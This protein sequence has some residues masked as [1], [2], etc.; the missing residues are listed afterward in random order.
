MR[1]NVT[2]SKKIDA[3][4]KELTKAV[5][6]L[7]E[8]VGSRAVSMKKAQRAAA[9]VHLAAIRYS[10]EVEAKTGLPSPFG[11]ALAPGLDITTISSLAAER[12]A[13]AKRDKK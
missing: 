10:A 4:R 3:A 7:A 5:K 2:M 13:I 12:D 11:E 9:E 6:H 8:V 1:K